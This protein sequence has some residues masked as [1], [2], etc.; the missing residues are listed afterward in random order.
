MNVF[1]FNLCFCIEDLFGSFF[2]V[3]NH[4]PFLGF[5]L[6]KE[7]SD[8]EKE[9]YEIFKDYTVDAFIAA[10]SDK[11][12]VLVPS[13]ASSQDYQLKATETNRWVK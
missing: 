9:F 8:I 6:C 1:E 11:F 7:H 4:F 3:L 2:W 10:E 12:R 13:N 5:D